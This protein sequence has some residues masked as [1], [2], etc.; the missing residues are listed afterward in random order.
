MLTQKEV[1]EK[2]EKGESLEGIE[3]GDLN[4]E[5]E[6]FEKNVNFNR[7]IFLSK[8]DFNHVCFK[9]SASFGEAIFKREAFFYDA[10]FQV[11]AGFFNTE[12]QDE[13][14]FSTV[15]FEGNANFGGAKFQ[16]LAF[17]SG[18]VFMGGAL[19]ATA[20]FEKAVDF[21]KCEF[22][23]QIDFN[24]SIFKSESNF[25]STKFNGDKTVVIFSR[26]EFNGRV[27]FENAT[28]QCTAAFIFV[29]FLKDIHF[30]NTNFEGY[31]NFKWS[32]FL[33]EVSFEDVIFAKGVDFNRVR[34]YAITRFVGSRDNK[35][36]SDKYIS[37]LSEVVFYKPQLTEF[38]TI[39]FSRCLLNR[40]DLRFIGL[41]DIIWAKRKGVNVVYDE[42]VNETKIENKFIE[43]AYLQLKKN[44]E[45]SKNYKEASDFHIGEMRIRRKSN[46]LFFKYFS[47]ISF[48]NILSGYGESYKRA[49][50]WFIFFIIIFTFIYLFTGLEEFSQNGDRLII[51]YDSQINLDNKSQIINT[52]GKCFIHTLE[53][54]SWQLNRNYKSPQLEGKLIEYFERIIIL[55]QTTLMILAFRRT[56][57]R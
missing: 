10:H 46:R 50:S 55:I 54:A 4:F 22:H 2:I 43:V 23:G 57:R 17:F 31:V 1:L 34:F 35:V 13:A 26:A 32:R 47:I 14:R 39:N 5:A 3:I 48:Y 45:E 12:F 18:S 8:A 41:I 56:F 16:H 42:I 21:F 37:D 33:D 7:A 27:L 20:K 44:F 51:K 6:V 29:K 30:Y 9:G 15:E 24:N 38:R 25:T 11:N 36:F 53:I 19:F 40:T 28:I 52:V 49:V